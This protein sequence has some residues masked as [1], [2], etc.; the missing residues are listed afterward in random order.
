MCIIFNLPKLVL[1]FHSMNQF[2]N[3]SILQFYPKYWN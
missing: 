1:Y 2:K 3:K